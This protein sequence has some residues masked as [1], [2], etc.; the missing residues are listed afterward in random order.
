[1]P[2]TP[3]DLHWALQGALPP[4]DFVLP[5]LLP[6]SLGLIVAPGDTGKTYLALDMAIAQAIGRPVAGG[7]FPA[8]TAAKVV[9]LAGEESDRLLAERLRGMVDLAE[10]SLPELH[11]NLLLLP[12]SGEDCLLLAKGEPTALFGELQELARG[13]RLI[14]VDPVRRLHDGD[15]ND[16][17]QM[18]KLVILLEWLAKSTG[19]AVL[20]PQHAN[21]AST[22]D[23]SSQHA[24]R[25]SS[26]LVDGA[27]W[28]I[29]LSRMDDRTAGMYGINEDERHLYVALDYAKCNYLAL[30]PRVWLKRQPGGALKLVALEKNQQTKV[31]G[32][33]RVI[34]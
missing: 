22:G 6:G 15:E 28:Q 31:V 32:G 11:R 24:A 2:L 26:A 16:S 34:R 14:I 5:G 4:L 30:R 8:L 10:R 20:G 27:R 9:F 7:L 21:K 1:M 33:A 23:S 19:A 3:L 25:G 18:T 17:A 13:A 12:R 29:N